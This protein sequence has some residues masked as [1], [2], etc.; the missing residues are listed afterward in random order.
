MGEDIT[1]NG[2]AA[3]DRPE[4]VTEGTSR[5]TYDEITLGTYDANN[6][7]AGN[8]FDPT[9]EY[10]HGRIRAVHLNVEAASYEAQ[11]D[12]DNRSIRV[13]NISDGTEVAQGTALDID[14]RVEVRGT[15]A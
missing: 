3:R 4:H 13:Y 8:A 10:G 9:F 11:Y 12:Y 7:G 15:G 14:I 6:D 2:V 1:H 5:V